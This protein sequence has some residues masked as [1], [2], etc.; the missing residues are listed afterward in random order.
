MNKKYFFKWKVI[1]CK[2]FGWHF[3]ASPRR[4]FILPPPMRRSVGLRR[5]LIELGNQRYKK[6]GGCCEECGQHFDRKDLQMHHILP[7]YVFPKLREEKWNLLLLCPR[8]HYM[9]HHNPLLQ[10]KHMEVVARQHSVELEKNYRKVINNRW[11][12]TQRRK[13]TEWS[14]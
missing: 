5:R 3:Y 12:E 2:L 9:E 14:F 13:E 4:L 6:N 10:A 1:N 8:C 7:W 11:E